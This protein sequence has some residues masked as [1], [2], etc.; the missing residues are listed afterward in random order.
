MN[1]YRSLDL[2][3]IKNRIA[4]YASISEA[5]EY[6]FN[7]EVIFN[8]LV[9]K[10]NIIETKEALAILNDGFIVNFD[11]INNVG[12]YFDKADKG[13]TLN[14]IELLKILVLHNHCSR[15]KKQFT[16]FD[17]E[18]HIRDYTDSLV[19]DNSVFL[20]IENCIDNNGEIKLDCTDELRRVC[21]ELESA[22][23]SLYS[24]AY[25]FVDKHM[26]SL[27]EPSLFERNNRVVFLIKNSDKNKYGG[28]AYGS[29]SSGLASYVE[30]SVMVELNNKRIQLLEAKED[31]INRI[32]KHLTYVVSGVSSMYRNNFES[33][34][35]LNVIFAKA[36][37]GYARNGIMADISQDQYFEYSDICHPLINEKKVISN[38]Y[39]LYSPYKGIVI[40]GSNTGGKTVS[41][42]LI[43]LA[44]VCTYLGIPLI[45]SKAI[46][47]IYDDVL[48]DIDDNQS[49]QDSLST[50][51]SHITNID[52]ILS[53][54]SDKSLILIDELVSGT[55]PKQ[56]QAISLAII[57]KIKEIGASFVITTH[58]DEIKNY[59]Y[60]D[61]SILLSAVSF[62][63]ETLSPT[64][65][66][67]ENA[68]GSSNALEIASRYI[69]D[70]NIIDKAHY[71]LDLKQ[72][73]EDELINKLAKQIEETSIEKEKLDN[74]QEEN[75]LLKEQLD[76]KLKSFDS[77]KSIMRENYL[78]ELSDFIENEKKKT[79][80][81]LQNL[82]SSKDINK[83]EEVVQE[84]IAKPVVSEEIEE[85]IE[86]GDN[87]RINDNEQ[88]GTI[89]EIRNNNVVVN[90]RGINVKTTINNLKKMP[91]IKT[92]DTKIIKPKV[93]R[94]SSELNLVGQRVED[95]LILMEEYLDKANA[96][97]LSSVK[98]IHGIGTGTLRS[99]LRE[100]MKKIKY[101]DKYHDGDFYDGGSAVTIVE[102][103]K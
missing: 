9:I 55:D 2:P 5:K 68:V 101:I 90:V 33:L 81:R 42:K 88:I 87:V 28:Y 23:K 73:K 40:S 25:Q 6:I 89:V 24:R 69:S 29:S 3:I 72:T 78:K 11:G 43:G 21:K 59:S 7:Q 71:Y 18:L 30:P 84:S 27:Q 52:Q 97:S 13:I 83:I 76:A 92:N 93:A 41:L 58:Y 86:V 75:R 31:E 102:F 46:V 16:N 98:I 15:L 70:K 62:N 37:Y 67:L 95:G 79:I 74:L 99:A 36:T 103:K 10:N 65:H 39:R 61:D 45:A 82:H 91:K 64:Y 17:K 51:S 77:E 50:F 47:P 60:N 35:K 56:A 12:E 26:S 66:Y 48:V 22:E 54:A 96:S 8:P 38:S 85:K 53:K 63:M 44:T 20:K 100:R 94:V 1:D 34:V 19:I 57:D 14:G 80:S 32:L 4:E 49:I